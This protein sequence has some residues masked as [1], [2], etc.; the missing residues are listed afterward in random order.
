MREVLQQLGS[1]RRRTRV[2]LIVQEVAAIVAGVIAAALLLIAVDWA[3]RLP[4]SLRL[5]L[6][7]AGA[8]ALTYSIVR[9]LVPALSF[10][11]SLTQIALRAERVMPRLSG[12]L[13]SSVEFMLADADQGNALASRS[14]RETESRLT[15]ESVFSVINAR[16]A[17]WC[18]AAMLLAIG[19]ATAFA[20]ASPG[21]AQIGA[22]RLFMPFGSAK[23][24]ART[25]V[26]SLMAAVAPGG[27]HARG[28]LLP[29]RARVTKGDPQQTVTAFYRFQREG[30]MQPWQRD[31]LT[32]QSSQGLQERLIETN[33]E[34]VEIYFQTDDDATETERIEL[35]PPPAVRRASLIVDP[36]DYA[37]G[38]VPTAQFELGTGTDD[39]FAT[40]SRSLV[41]SQATLTLEL[42]KP[43]PV[44]DSPSDRATWITNTFGWQGA[45]LPEFQVDAD[46]TW[47][48]RWTIAGTRD[49]EMNLVDDVG[50]TNSEPIRF[51]VHAV[52]DLAPAVSIVDPASDQ[53]V[54][55]TAVVPITAE[56]HDDVAVAEARLEAYVQASDASQPADEAAWFAV[57]ESTGPDAVAAGEIQLEKLGLHEGDF[58][59]VFAVATDVYELAGQTH[60][61]VRSTVRK[62]R[63]ISDRELG[64]ILRREL[65]ALRQNAIRVE[66]Q[67][68]ELQETAEQG[69]LGPPLGSMQARIG[70]RL[71]QQHETI[72]QVEKSMRTNRMDDPELRDVVGAVKETL[73]RAG[74]SSNRAVEKIREAQDKLG[75]E[76]LQDEVVEAQ[77]EVREELA[78]LI[79]QLD[80]NEDAWVATRMLQDLR[81]AQDELAAATE[82]AAQQTLGRERDEL[83]PAEL[84]E[85]ERIAQRQR[86]LADSIPQLVE[87]LRN[88]AKELE[89]NDQQ[90]ASGLRA[91]A[92]AAE[93]MELERDMEQAAQ[94]LADNQMNTAQNSQQSANQT[95]Q[96]M[97]ED[98][99]AMR[100]A[101]A[102]ELQRQLASLIQ[103]IDRLI[104]VQTREIEMLKAAVES[105]DFSGRDQAMVRLSQNTRVVASEAREAGQEARRAART[106]D[107]AAETQGEA[108]VALRKQPLDSEAADFSERASLTL[109]E[110]AKKLA[111]ETLEDLQDKQVREARE[112][113]LEEYKKFAE[114]QATLRD[115]TARLQTLDPLDRQRLVEARQVSAAQEDLRKAIFDMREKSRDLLEAIVFT[116]AHKLID[117]WATEAVDE[118]KQG[119]VDEVVTDRQQQI[120]SSLEQLVKALEQLMK[121]PSEFE[122]GN[123]NQGAGAGGASGQDGQSQLIPPIA[124]LRLLRG[125]QEH[126]YSQTR[127]LEE[128]GDMDAARRRTQLRELGEQQRDLSDLGK[129]IIENLRNQAGPPIPEQGEIAPDGGEEKPSVP[130]VP[131][132]EA[133]AVDISTTHVT[134]A[135]V[136]AM[137]QEEPAKTEGDEPA[138]ADEDEEKDGAKSLDELL[139]L[140]EEPGA[141]S[142]AE[143][144]AKKELER[145][146]NDEEVI[147]AF[148]QT[149]E[150]MGFA[151]TLL[152]EQ[153]DPGL[154]TQ[155]VQE[156]I[157]AQLDTI[158]NEVMQ[159]N[160]SQQSSSSSSSSNS[161]N[162]K[163]Q[164]P[165]N[166]PPSQQQPGQQNS[167]QRNQNPADAEEGDPPPRQ[168]GDLNPLI[169][170][171]RT[172]WGSLP[173]RVRDMLQQGRRETYSSLYERLT[174]E[175]YRRLA[176]EGS[177]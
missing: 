121:P 173:D 162:R 38:H 151:A 31:L 55:A 66:A 53:A 131:Q 11:P 156:D 163:P 37:V 169:D 98:M 24:P 150:K 171:G 146:L 7:V 99:Q 143:A 60:Q 14:I 50:L 128:R 35:V 154:G 19:G 87:Q 4:S 82:K 104:N 132:R 145:K 112:Q 166:T 170:E 106:L 114:D 46:D 130:P 118:L 175:Y 57:G 32:P 21:M 78:D 52:D 174:Q 44:E 102:L 177:P 45:A 105:G 122:D 2:M 59:H 96:Q 85:L 30:R 25:G 8:A 51:R 13:A 65:G 109:L 172:E 29:I 23:W 158:I 113:L 165:Q 89:E 26:E 133:R 161:Q 160:Q 76:Q 10:R 69:E 80:S 3:L 17:R 42:T 9:W 73:N 108:V 111:S 74:Q 124:E 84:S 34:A 126:V 39:R 83:T 54:L 116:H 22:S 129:T 101:E 86:E 119:N 164:Q 103:S 71:A 92:D 139:G 56:A 27:A 136:L 152:D 33:A 5:L 144:Q 64:T 141:T 135:T 110:E 12:R 72:E 68:G 62:L 43:L 125:L 67:Q 95:I 88:R 49:I 61:P 91:A 48:L 134:L 16:R 70:E 138:A 77:Q 36:P 94:Q 18:I 90:T 148:E 63:I 168:N 107:R 123:Q 117:R 167:N 159:M 28:Q 127:H 41:G 75:D 58:V 81:D 40:E 6:L 140:E 153:F 100:R 79:R 15:G 97:M 93:R 47:S 137:L 115:H 20:A 142:A 149:V 155:R 147:D 1:V 176:E 157:L 120:V